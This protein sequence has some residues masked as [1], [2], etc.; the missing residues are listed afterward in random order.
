MRRAGETLLEVAARFLSSFPRP[1]TL[2]VAVSGGSDSLG[3]LLALKSCLSSGRHPGLSLHACTVDHALRAGSAEEARWV[4][5]LCARH[6]IAH[7]IR[8]WDGDKPATGVQAAARAARYDLL[9]A[10]AAKIGADAVLTG[11]TADDQRETIAMRTMRAPEGV[12]LSGM[13]GAVLLSGRFWLMRPLLCVRRAEMRSF[14]SSAGEGWL[15]D[16]SNANPRFERVRVRM[17]RDG[18][19]AAEASDRL[20]LS[21]RA[22]AF[23]D[24][25]AQAP[26]PHLFRLEPALLDEAIG[27]PAAWRGLL[28]LAA[29][30]GGRV[31][32][33]E[34]AAAER[35]RAFVG[36]G[37]LS[38]LT[39]GRVV[40]DRRRD[41]L[42][43]YR[44]RRGLAA[45]EVPAGET[46]VWDGRFRVAN[47]WDRPF[48]VMPGDPAGSGLSGPARRAAKAA[49]FAC[50]DDDSPLPE[51]WP[52]LTPLVAPYA[53]FL[54]RFDLP[55][56]QV[57]ARL[58]G[59]DPFPLPP[60][61]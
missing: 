36:S 52:A 24:R 32:P 37:I 44:E 26:Q 47:R 1:A 46:V 38:R 17:E 53:R 56:A 2:L 29:T 49:P 48:V 35:L 57:L 14:L 39:A 5:A 34:R 42:F 51:E 30:A 23:L 10:A 19:A 27:D 33:V 6:G 15:E 13:A 22:A 8:R 18:G 9:C 25:C 16:P 28:L 50:F 55:L 11:H 40:F 60:N 21:V 58:A 12:G 54:P 20:A 3:L 7:S 43:L 61:E 59:C 4:G 31:H 41:G 45:I